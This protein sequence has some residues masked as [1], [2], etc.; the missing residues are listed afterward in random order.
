ME[1][2]IY[3]YGIIPETE[4]IPSFKGLDDV[5]DAYSL[6]LGGIKAIVCDL[7]EAEYNE[8]KL[9]EKVNDI[10]WLHEKA[11]HHHETLAALNKGSSVIPMKFCTIYQSEESLKEKIE[12]RKKAIIN[13]LS[14]LNHKEE[15]NLKIYCDDEKWEKSFKDHNLIIEE[16][17]AKIE[18]LS[19]G[20]QFFAKKKL[21]KWIKEEMDNKKD[22][23]CYDIYNELDSIAI[24]STVKKNWSKDVTGKQEDMSWNS[25]YLLSSEH[26]DKLATYLE[27]WKEEWEEKGWKFEVTGPWPPYHFASL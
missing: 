21:D 7:D 23:F 11:F 4:D 14:W 27:Q 8:E 17:K 6:S 9:E 16:K 2:L 25:V 19:P 1:Q 20:K 13:L 12:P 22:S 26:V 15:W 18:Q 24:E 5:H 10:E 3:L